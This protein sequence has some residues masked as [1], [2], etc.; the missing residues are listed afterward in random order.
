MSEFH[1]EGW[2]SRRHSR[3]CVQDKAIIHTDTSTSRYKQQLAYPCHPTKPPE[4]DAKA[5]AWTAELGADRGPQQLSPGNGS[6][7]SSLKLK[8]P[9]KAQL[10]H[11]SGKIAG[12]IGHQETLFQSSLSKTVYYFHQQTGKLITEIFRYCQ[13]LAMMHLPIKQPPL[14][15]PAPSAMGPKHT[16]HLDRVN[17]VIII[18]IIIYRVSAG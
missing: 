12:K 7:C 11:E 6:D 3:E 8:S 14:N 15:A 16:D 2:P 18:I 4:R 9:A 13:S 1:Q 10:E 5:E 17:L